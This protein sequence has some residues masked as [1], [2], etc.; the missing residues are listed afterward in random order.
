[1]GSSLTGGR[2]PV[3]LEKLVV[4]KH[5]PWLYRQISDPANKPLILPAVGFNTDVDFNG[6]L[7]EQC[8]R[9][10]LE[11]YL[12]YAPEGKE[13]IGF[14]YAYD[15]RPADGHCRLCVFVDREH[16]SAGYGAYAALRF[17][18]LLFR[19]YPLR[20]VYSAVYGY[21]EDSLRNC[22]GAGFSEEARMRE[23]R[24]HDGAYWDLVLLSLT[25]ERFDGEL[26]S[27]ERRFFDGA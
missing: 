12:V 10:F 20:K 8:R 2:G 18:A 3:A 17:L 26:R 23:Y 21:N 13:P 7:V 24:Y 11:F 4:G 5:G 1:M 16:R 19:S 14:V 9:S 22:L 25:R 6:W 15:H 27:Y